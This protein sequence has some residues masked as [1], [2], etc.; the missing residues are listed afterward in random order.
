MSTMM[1]RPWGQ[2]K[3]LEESR[4]S[5]T[6]RAISSPERV[7]CTLMAAWQAREAVMRSRTRVTCDDFSYIEA[8][9][10][11]R[12]KASRSWRS[13]SGGTAEMA[14]A[15][16]EKRSMSKPT[17]RSSSRCDSSTAHSAAPVS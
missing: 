9:M 3:G 2:A 4:S 16:P 13:N 12:R 15:L 14:K 11:L 5:A 10:I 1:G 7:R 6:R 8:S 17:A